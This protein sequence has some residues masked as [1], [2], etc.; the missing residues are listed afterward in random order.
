MVRRRVTTLRQKAE[1]EAGNN[2]A[3]ATEL[4][5]KAAKYEAEALPSLLNEDAFVD[6]LGGVSRTLDKIEEQL[7]TTLSL[8]DEC[9]GWLLG[10]SFSAVDIS[11]SVIL[12]KL[13]LLGF[14]EYFWARGKRPHVQKFLKEIQKRASFLK[15]VSDVGSPTGRMVSIQEDTAVTAPDSGVGVFDAD[16]HS[17]VMSEMKAVVDGAGEEHQQGILKKSYID[18]KIEEKKYEEGQEVYKDLENGILIEVPA[19]KKGIEEERTWKSL[20]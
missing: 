8:E 16:E 4:R 9:P 5:Q 12:N 7:T 18:G 15:S 17:K 1:D 14:Q 11:L 3:A 19:E 20:W 10:A 13:A 6:L 2:P